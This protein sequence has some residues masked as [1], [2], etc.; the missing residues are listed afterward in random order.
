MINNT[1]KINL[2][3]SKADQVGK[4]ENT[5][6]GILTSKISILPVNTNVFNAPFKAQRVLHWIKK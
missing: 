5:G 2:E 4:T 6:N 1:F 3:D